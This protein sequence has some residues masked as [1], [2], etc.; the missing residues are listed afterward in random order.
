[1][2]RNFLLLLIGLLSACSTTAPGSPMGVLA[3]EINATLSIGKTVLTPG[4]VLEVR[5]ARLPDWNQQDVTV[6]VDGRAVFLSLDDRHVAG[7]TIAMLDAM[8]T[9]EYAKILTQPELTVR[10]TTAAPRNVVVM[11]EVL[12]GG[13]FELPAGRLSLIEALGLSEGF[14]RDTAKLDHTMLVRWI[15]EEN[16]VQSWKIDASLDEWGASESILLQPHDVIY[17]PAK[18]I[19]H[20][21]DW[22]DRYIRRMIPFPYLTFLQ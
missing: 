14:I 10:V 3:P 15:P 2:L 5:F 17:I 13:T 22:M 6:R 16:R 18:P 21:N 1:M 19:V 12:G 20:V 11:G 7:M 9:E 4:D 8:L